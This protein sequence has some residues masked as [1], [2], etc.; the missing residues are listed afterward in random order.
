ML[1]Y[2]GT[3]LDAF[4]N[5]SKFSCS[6]AIKIDQMFIYRIIVLNDIL[7]YRI[8]KDFLIILTGRFYLCTNRNKYISSLLF[9]SETRI[10]T[11]SE[12]EYKIRFHLFFIGFIA[13]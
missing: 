10:D 9:D 7:K 2:T 5:K 4:D 12:M 8:K 3:Q 11:I 13:R 1:S 6:S